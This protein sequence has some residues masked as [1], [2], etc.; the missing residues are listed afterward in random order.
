MEVEAR[1]HKEQDSGMTRVQIL[2]DRADFDL[3]LTTGLMPVEDARQ[4]ANRMNA[5]GWDVFE[6]WNR[7]FGFSSEWVT[8][9]SEE[10]EAN[11]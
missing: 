1:I 7:P 4:L 11:A 5:C 3:L 8:V 10:R 6:R 9:T 2:V